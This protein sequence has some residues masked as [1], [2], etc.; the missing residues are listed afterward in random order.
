MSGLFKSAKKAIKNPFDKIAKMDPIMNTI[1]KKN[2][3]SKA[4]KFLYPSAAT[5]DRIKDGDSTTK[6]I[7][8]PAAFFTESDTQEGRQKEADAAAAAEAARIAAIMPSEDSESIA[9]AKRKSLLR[10]RGRGGRQSTVLTGGAADT[11][12]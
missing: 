10:Q 5:A 12:G 4:M 9:A 8:D 6:A 2:D 1:Y 7:G 11:L 3:G